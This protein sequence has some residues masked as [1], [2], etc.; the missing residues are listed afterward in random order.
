MAGKNP[1][2]FASKKTE[3]REILNDPSF[4]DLA[5]AMGGCLWLGNRDQI[6][7]TLTV[8]MKTFR[9]FIGG[10][11]R[12]TC[13]F[14]FRQESK[15]WQEQHKCKNKRHFFQDYEATMVSK[16]WQTRSLALSAEANINRW[17]N[18]YILDLTDLKFLRQTRKNFTA[19]VKNSTDEPS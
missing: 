10:M 7:Y 15:M 16:S 17:H 11:Y 19:G 14:L 13:G 3:D 18:R 8:N 5:D 6:T 4:I 1:R 12:S 2:K 9:I